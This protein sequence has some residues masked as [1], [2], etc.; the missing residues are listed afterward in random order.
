MSPSSGTGARASFAL[1]LPGRLVS[2]LGTWV[3][4]FATSLYV[5]DLTGSAGTFSAVLAL[6]L[7]P[8]VVVNLFAGVLVDRYDKKRILISCEAASAVVVALLACAFWAGIVGVPLLVLAVIL[9]G[10]IQAVFVVGLNA[11]VRHVVSDADVAKM[12][13]GLQAV[14]AIVLIAGPTCGAIAYG[15]LGMGTIAALDGVT[16]LASVALLLPLRYHGAGAAE[17]A[18]G[19]ARVL[20]SLREVIGY[21]NAEGTIKALLVYVMILQAVINPLLGMAL[22]Y[23]IYKRL[24]LSVVDLSVIQTAAALGTITGAAILTIMPVHRTLLRRFFLL[25]GFQALVIFFWMFP[26]LPLFAHREKT[27]ITTI[28]AALAFVSELALTVQ[29]IPMLTHFQL[30]IP[31]ALFG[32]VF[33]IYAAAMSALVPATTWGLGL[34]LD[35]VSWT[36]VTTA[37]AVVLAIVCV[38]SAWSKTITVFLAGIERPIDQ[39]GAA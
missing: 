1:M 30:T 37:G 24:E 8:A 10:A 20:Q 26:E 18:P 3:F 38:S 33:S 9:L 27:T 36:Y 7:L 31:T 23:V 2:E 6:G 17:A 11:S 5:I 19:S 32:R 21:L 39:P 13:S 16:F 25:M 4:N 35:R 14:G 15:T 22:P 34:V 12:N 28:Y 29:S